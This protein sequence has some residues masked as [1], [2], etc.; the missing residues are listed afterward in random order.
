MG[1]SYLIGGLILLAISRKLIL[2]RTLVYLSIMT[3]ASTMFWAF[4][5][6]YVSPA[7][8]AVLSYSMPLF[9]LPIA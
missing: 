9:S 5:L 3:A 4:G 8:S 2:T 7:E 1:L 6:M